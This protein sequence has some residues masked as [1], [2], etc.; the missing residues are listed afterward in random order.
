[1]IVE[2]IYEVKKSQI[3][4]WPVVA[5]RASEVGDPCERYLVL[6]RTRWQ[7]RK[8]HEVDLQMIF[9]DGNMH[10]KKVIRDIEDCG[11]EVIEQHRAFEW[12]EYGITG[13]LDAKVIVDGK[14]IPV[15]IKSCQS[16]IFNSI[17]T[18]QDMINHKVSYIRKY[19]TQLSL[20]LLMDNKD[21]GVFI[22]KDKPHSKLK[23]IPFPL[24][25]DYAESILQKVERVN[26]HIKEGTL[27]DTYTDADV[28]S[29]CGFFH[30]CLPVM[31]SQGLEFV[32]DPEFEEKLKRREEL[33]PLVKEHKVLDDEVKAKTKNVE[34][35][36]IG[37]YLITGKLVSK[38]GFTVEPSTYWQAK[39]SRIG[40]SD[41]E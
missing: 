30:I 32:D 36:V 4:Q 12:R 15:E 16:Y 25:Y 9:E 18:P 19:P 35:K 28:C 41:S 3:R 29:R 6:L 10:E 8:M 21:F 33:A 38:K 7:E 11:L 23:E 5:N 13:Q 27:P 26:K 22:F 14:V 34:K 20:Y 2:R 39:I 40:E 24:D 31:Q 17:N 1:M 37:N